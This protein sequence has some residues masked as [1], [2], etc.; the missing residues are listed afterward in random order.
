MTTY[1]NTDFITFPVS[2]G[3]GRAN[4]YPS[5]LIVAGAP[6][7]ISQI[8]VSLNDVNQTFSEDIA[9]M[10]ES[11]S[12][13]TLPLMFYNGGA[14][15]IVNVDLTFDDNAPTTLPTPIVSG[16]YK[17][18]PPTTVPSLP[19]PDFL[20]APLT[21]QPIIYSNLLTKAFTGPGKN[22]NGTWKLWV[23]DTFP[24]ADNGSIDGWSITIS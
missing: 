2:S 12:G 8:T 1:T 10:L 19:L 6:T 23:V 24:P 15:V 7:T 4:I 3:N 14:A 20:G 11:P 13:N 16:T 18:T 17:V 22:P 21:Q 5:N 9:V